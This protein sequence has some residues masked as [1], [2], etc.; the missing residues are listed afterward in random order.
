MRDF[1]DKFIR[2]RV[3]VASWTRAKILD[4][5]QNKNAKIRIIGTGQI[6]V[7][8]LVSAD[9]LPVKTLSTDFEFRESLKKGDEIDYLDSKSWLRSTVIEVEERIR[10]SV[11]C[12]F[13]KYGLRVYRSNGKTKDSRGNAYFGWNENFDKDVSVHDPRLRMPN[14]HSKIIE[15]Y[16]ILTTYPLDS[17]NFND[18]ETH[19]PVSFNFLF[20]VRD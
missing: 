8:S 12:K 2:D 7:V 19:L 4:I 9:V 16:E 18:L 20:L 5:E 10:G 3:S 15:N 17:K 6:E 1:E 11:K 14:Q 13:I